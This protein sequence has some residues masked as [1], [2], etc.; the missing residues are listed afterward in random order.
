MSIDQ[1]SIDDIVVKIAEHADGIGTIIKQFSQEELG[2][3]LSNFSLLALKSTIDNSVQEIKRNVYMLAS[4]YVPDSASNSDC[5][6]VCS[7]HGSESIS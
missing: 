1:K 7:D 6:K 3:K 4:D 2:N 5:G